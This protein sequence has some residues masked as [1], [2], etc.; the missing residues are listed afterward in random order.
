[1]VKVLSPEEA[2]QRAQR[3]QEGRIDAIRGLAEVRQSSAD[4][5]EAVARR[6]AEVKRETDA[7]LADAERAD[8]RAYAAARA[9]GWSIDELR[10]VGFD[11]PEKV[12]R[13]TRRGRARTAAGA[14]PARDATD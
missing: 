3:A 14:E 11:E 4:V 8:A 7:Q 10:K 6:L 1:M 9:A 5:A 12:Q 2:V 13:V